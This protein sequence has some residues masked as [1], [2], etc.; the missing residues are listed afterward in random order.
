MVLLSSSVGAGRGV[1]VPALG[2]RPHV[3]AR[4]TRKNRHLSRHGW[5]YPCRCRTKESCATLPADLQREVSASVAFCKVYAGTNTSAGV[6]A[7][8]DEFFN[9]V[10]KDDLTT[11]PAQLTM[12]PAGR[13]VLATGRTRAESATAMAAQSRIADEV[14]NSLCCATSVLLDSVVNGREDNVADQAI[15]VGQALH[16]AEA[17]V[18]QSTEVVQQARVKLQDLATH[19]VLLANQEASLAAAGGPVL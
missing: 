16:R 11:L 14:V 2:S 12:F 5:H 6:L 18:R 10:A 3:A 17:G 15:M 1:S 4:H 7:E 13:D 8:V 9:H 19:T